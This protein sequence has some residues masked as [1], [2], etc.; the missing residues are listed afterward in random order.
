MNQF[1]VLIFLNKFTY[2]MKRLFFLKIVILEYLL[3]FKEGY[4]LN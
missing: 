1:F 4:G 2:C 3:N